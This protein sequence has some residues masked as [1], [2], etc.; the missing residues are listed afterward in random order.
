MNEYNS[1]PASDDPPRTTSISREIFSTIGI[2]LLAGLI[3]V[4]LTAFVFQSYQVEGP[5]MQTT[6]QDKDRLVVWKLPRTWARLTHHQYIPQRGDVIIFVE[7]GLAQFG[8]DNTKQLIKRTI[9]LPG[10]RVVVKDGIVTIYNPKHPA[11]FQPDKTLPYGKVIPVTPGDNI[12]YTLGPNE[13][14]VCGDNRPDSLDSRSFGPISTNQVVGKLVIRV[15]P[16]DTV[17][18]F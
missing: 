1:Q 11:G 3:A 16:L 9:G 12:D 17:K 15:F 6:L 14:F 4:G 18:K 7:K 2:L 13:L 5:S 8:Q 10:D